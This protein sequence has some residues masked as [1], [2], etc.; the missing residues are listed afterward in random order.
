MGILLI[1]DITDERS[2]NSMYEIPSPFLA[3]WYLADIRSW[4][5]NV[6]QHAS[7]SVDKILIGNKTDWADKRVVS[8]DKGEEL[9][10]EFGIKF[11]E[12]SARLNQGVEEVFFT[13]TRYEWLCTSI[14]LI[15]TLNPQRYQD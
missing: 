3:L 15:S 2:F 5:A 1:Y 4:H 7:D 11:I 9:A 6:E 10:R 13:L 12:T 8:A 14:S